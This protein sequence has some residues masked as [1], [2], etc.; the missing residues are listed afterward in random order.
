MKPLRRTIA[1]IGLLWTALSPLAAIAQAPPAVPALPD[2]ERR[3]AYSI[4]TSTCACAVNMALY[5]TGNDV[6]SWIQV[7][8]NGV[9]KLSTDPTY[10]WG[11]TSPTGSLSTIPRPITDAILTFTSPQTATIQI[12]GAERPRQLSQFQENRGVAAR[13]L[14]QRFTEDRAITREL[15]D[16]TND[17]TGRGLFFQPGITTGAMPQPAVCENSLL[18]FDISG[19]NPICTNVNTYL[20]GPALSRTQLN[21]N[22]TLYVNG[23]TGSDSNSGLTSGAPFLTLQKAANVICD[24]YDLNGHTVLV[25]GSDAGTYTGSY[26]GFSACKYLGYLGSI[27]QQSVV[28]RGAATISSSCTNY[29]TV[30]SGITSVGVSVPWTVTNFQIDAKVTA[31]ALSWIALDGNCYGGVS[32]NPQLVADL[33]SIIEFINN[34]FTINGGSAGG[35][36]DAVTGG[37]VIWQTT[38]SPVTIVGTPN[39]NG[40]FAT[41]TQGGIIDCQDITFTGSLAASTKRYV[42]DATSTLF[43]GKTGVSVDPNTVLPGDT[44]G[45]GL[46]TFGQMFISTGPGSGGAYIG[47]FVKPIFGGNGSTASTSNSTQ[48]LSLANI[49][50]SEIYFMISPANYALTG[51]YVNVNTAPGAGQTYTF[52][53]RTGGVDSSVTCQ[54]S[55]ASAL[56]CSDTTHSVSVTASSAIDVKMVSSS[57]AAT[58]I[59]SWSVGAQ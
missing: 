55:G 33:N 14:N 3:T 18:G 37:A 28:V 34:P 38:A 6:D 57:S 16:K 1:A 31:D 41:A 23:S 40:Q 43:C 11:L 47:N 46:G 58:T 5:G 4:S 10:G 35:F 52:T 21:V 8:V 20:P 45:T 19:V 22:L 56:A 39:M 48:Y 13:D 29:P 24:N 7:W 51:F 15:W 12:V 44:T 30:T 17:L 50:T 2:S 9:R 54:I 42:V 26:T 25:D 59:V 27:G 32:G 36:V 49:S 53:L